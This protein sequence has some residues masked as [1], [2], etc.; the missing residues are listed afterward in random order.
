MRESNPPGRVHNAK[1]KPLGQRHTE[2]HGVP[3]RCEVAARKGVEPSYPER[4]SGVLPLNYRAGV[5]A[6]G[7]GFEPVSPE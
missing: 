6:S 2:M 1:P 4:Q 7:T 3:W 5:L